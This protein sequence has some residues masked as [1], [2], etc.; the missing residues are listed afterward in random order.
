MAVLR[1]RRLAIGAVQAGNIPLERPASPLSTPETR[2]TSDYIY[3]CPSGI[4]A[5]VRHVD[6]WIESAWIPPDII[7][8]TFLGFVAW[9]ILDYN[10]GYLYIVGDKMATTWHTSQQWDGTAVLNPGDR[11]YVTSSKTEA[12]LHYQLSGA[13]LVIP[14]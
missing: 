12:D 8:E 9:G 11:I 6:F 10:Q 3:Q 1:T 2:G 7:A 13:E 5:V 4:R 14:A